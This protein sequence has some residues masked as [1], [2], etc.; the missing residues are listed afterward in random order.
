MFTVY[1]SGH[2][3][4]VLLFTEHIKE[5]LNGPDGIELRWH[6]TC[7]TAGTTQIHRGPASLQEVA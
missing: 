1:C 2:G 5:L 7:G 3:S 6:C 4:Q